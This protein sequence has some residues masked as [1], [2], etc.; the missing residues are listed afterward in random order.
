MCLLCCAEAVENKHIFTDSAPDL[1][2]SGELA[3]VCA[4]LHTCVT[5]EGASQALSASGGIPDWNSWDWILGLR[6]LGVD[7]LVWIPWFGF[8]GLDS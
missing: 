2:R 1:Q 5:R 6:F 8:L 7:S 4:P 3:I